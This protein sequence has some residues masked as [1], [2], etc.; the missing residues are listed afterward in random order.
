MAI[1]ALS[2]KPCPEYV[3]GR[4]GCLYMRCATVVLLPLRKCLS[5]NV[6]E[7]NLGG[8]KTRRQHQKY[9]KTN[10]N[11]HRFQWRFYLW[12]ILGEDSIES[13]HFW[14]SKWCT[15]VP[16]AGLG[17]ERRLIQSQ[18]LLPL[19]HLQERHGLRRVLH[20]YR[21]TDPHHHLHLLRESR[22]EEVDKRKYYVKMLMQGK[23]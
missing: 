16:W 11:S 8:N 10:S 3:R 5:P 2:L 18:L 7:Y 6:L 21:W 4:M 20:P 14:S 15:S 22:K 13:K 19:V 9:H 1:F 12:G 17:Q 23:K